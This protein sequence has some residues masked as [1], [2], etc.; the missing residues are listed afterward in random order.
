[1][2][3][4][5]LDWGDGVDRGRRGELLPASQGVMQASACGPVARSVEVPVG[6]GPGLQCPFGKRGPLAIL[7]KVG[8]AE[9]P[10]EGA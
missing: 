5:A 2:Q 10:E 7:W 9:P 6:D 1:M 4:P 8:E 3:L